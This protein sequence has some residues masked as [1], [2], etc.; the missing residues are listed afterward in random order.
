MFGGERL[1]RILDL[2]CKLLHIICIPFML[3]FSALHFL[4]TIY[5]FLVVPWSPLLHWAFFSCCKRGLF[6]VAVLEILIVVVSLIVA[7]GLQAHRLQ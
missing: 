4:K 6:F 3:S 1:A 2:T 7:Y 5:L